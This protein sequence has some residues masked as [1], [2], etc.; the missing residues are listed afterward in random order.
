MRANLRD[1]VVL[2]CSPSASGTEMWFVAERFTRIKDAWT[3]V[4][5]LKAQGKPARIARQ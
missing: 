5:A 3:C 1:F 2:C 4:H